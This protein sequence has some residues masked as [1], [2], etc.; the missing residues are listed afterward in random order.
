MVTVSAPSDART[1]PGPGAHV[2]R[3]KVDARDLRRE[4]VGAV[5][6]WLASAGIIA[7]NTQ[8]MAVFETDGRH[9][10]HVSGFRRIDSQIV[11][12]WATGEPIRESI[13]VA[14][15]DD[16]PEF[17]NDYA[18]E[19]FTWMSAGSKHVPERVEV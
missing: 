5:T 9:L 8:A 1:L 15:G 4:H 18:P 14:V 10:L 19:R 2:M 12:D 3:F 7:A 13:V 17:L 16:W 6:D 11:L